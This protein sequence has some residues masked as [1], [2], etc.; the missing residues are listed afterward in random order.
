[1]ISMDASLE[2]GADVYEVLKVL[3]ADLNVMYNDLL[4]QRAIRSAVPNDLQ[5]LVLQFVTHATRP[6]RILE[7]SE[8]AK[9]VKGPSTNRSLKETK[10]LVR[11]AC[12]PLLEILPDETGLGRSPLIHRVLERIHP[13]K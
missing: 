2:P 3:P 8:T 5:L 7:I 9:S 12:G 13:F 4:H 10:V 6:L 1:M 11:A